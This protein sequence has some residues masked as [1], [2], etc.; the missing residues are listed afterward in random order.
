MSTLHLDT[1]LVNRQPEERTHYAPVEGWTNADGDSF[2]S[3]RLDR[4][5]RAMLLTELGHVRQ[6]GD[7]AWVVRSQSGK[8]SYRVTADACECPDNRKTGAVCKHQLAGPF[9]IAACVALS[10]RYAISVV[11]LQRIC[12]TFKRD[13]AAMPKG[14][15]Q[16]LKLEYRKALAR[17]GNRP[18]WLQP[19]QGYYRLGGDGQGLALILSLTESGYTYRVHAVDTYYESTAWGPFNSRVDAIA[20]AQKFL[21]EHWTDYKEWLASKGYHV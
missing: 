10:F 9:F 21:Y 4:F 16:M 20:N 12:E 2:H 6:A 5:E 7:G 14:V 8:G 18:E 11:E 1:F 19:E 13:L 15:R 3:P 17:V